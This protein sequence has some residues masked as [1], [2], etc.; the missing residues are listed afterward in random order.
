MFRPAVVS[1]YV[2]EALVPSEAWAA[3][4]PTGAGISQYVIEALVPSEASVAV[5]SQYVI[6][7]LMADDGTQ[8]D[9][10]PPGGVGSDRVHVFGYAG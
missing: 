3:S 5:V 1:Q 6:E 7:A 9:P 8:T 4:T 10:T 2:I